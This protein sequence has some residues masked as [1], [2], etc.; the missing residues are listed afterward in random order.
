MLKRKLDHVTRAM[1]AFL[2]V[3]FW[4]FVVPLGVLNYF[5]IENPAV[6]LFIAIPTGVVAVLI[7]ENVL[8]IEY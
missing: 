4:L 5:E 6:V 8:G 2:N 1:L 7:N 3:I